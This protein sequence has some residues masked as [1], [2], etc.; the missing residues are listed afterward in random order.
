MRKKVLLIISIFS[1]IVANAQ[2]QDSLIVKANALF[3]QNKYQEAVEAYEKIL[4]EIGRASCR[5]RV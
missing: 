4:D 2:D 5:E 3:T 1:A